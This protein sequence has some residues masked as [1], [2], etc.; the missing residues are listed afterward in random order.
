MGYNN[1]VADVGGT[2]FERQANVNDSLIVFDLAKEV[3]ISV[4]V[5]VLAIDDNL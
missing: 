4:Q 3:I 1:R 2:E 5:H